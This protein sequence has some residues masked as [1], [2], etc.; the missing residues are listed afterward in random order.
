METN[1][2][3]P[4]GGVVPGSERGLGLLN[5]SGHGRTVS[6]QEGKQGKEK[7]CS[8]GRSLSSCWCGVDGAERIWLQNLALPHPS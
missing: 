1:L 2:V 8:W 3:R 5:D 7:S 6:S 4:R